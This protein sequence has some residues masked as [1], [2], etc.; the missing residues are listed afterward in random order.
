MI[1]IKKKVK[2]MSYQAGFVQWRKNGRPTL[3]FRERDSN[4]PNGW[5]ERRVTLPPRTTVK[6]AR[7][8]L[9]ELIA[10]VNSANADSSA[11]ATA[12]RPSVLTLADFVE[13]SLWKS[14]LARKKVK[15]STRA[16]YDSMILNHVLL[17]IGSVALKSMT[18]ATITCRI[19]CS[20]PRT[21]EHS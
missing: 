5:K 3:R 6:Q 14:Y 13:G 12:T 9:Y 21:V 19:S 17:H 1:M 20:K 18:K 11:V 7:K 10:I 8:K 16:A 2:R 15:P 4:S